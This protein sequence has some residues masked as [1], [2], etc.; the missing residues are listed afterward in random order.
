ME[1]EKVS[2]YLVGRQ[3]TIKSKKLMTSIKVED[4]VHESLNPGTNL[5]NQDSI[6]WYVNRYFEKVYEKEGVEDKY[7]DWFLNFLD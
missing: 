4:N 7:Q 2:A 6:E 1:G 3:N 5:E